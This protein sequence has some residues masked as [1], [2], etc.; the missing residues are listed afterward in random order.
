MNETK[1]RRNLKATYIVDVYIIIGRFGLRVMS[2]D[3]FLPICE[4]WYS[5]R[6]LSE[7]ANCL[8]SITI[9]ITMSALYNTRVLMPSHQ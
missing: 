9:S 3:I 2:H 1:L 7:C 6:I 5:F 4:F 8:I